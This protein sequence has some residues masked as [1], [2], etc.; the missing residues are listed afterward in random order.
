[1]RRMLIIVS[2][3]LCLGCLPAVVHAEWQAG[4]G[5]EKITP[6]QPM[7]L[8]GYGG[9]NQ[10]AEGTLHDLWAKAI[11]LQNSAGQRGVIISLDLVGISREMTAA[12]VKLLEQ[13][14]LFQRAEIAICTSHT[15]CGPVTAGTLT[16]MYFLDD[17]QQQLVDQYSA[18]LP[19][20]IVAAVEKALQHLE[21]VTLKFACGEATFAV[22]RRN[23]V[24]AEV[25]QLREAGLLEGPVD[26]QVPTLLVHDQQ[27]QV[28]G[29]V[30]GYACHATTLGFYQ[31][32][33]DWP[34]FAQLEI[35]KLYPQATAMFVA[36]CGA[37]QNP[38]PRRQVELAE[39]YGQQIA[40][41]IAQIPQPEWTSLP[42]DFR[43]QYQEL[44]LPLA[45]LPTREQ[46]ADEAASADR[47]VANRARLLLE[48]WEQT[49]QLASSYSYPVQVW[50]LGRV[51]IVFLGGEVVVDY[52]LRLK[53]DLQ[54]P[55]A[56]I[57][58]Y[59]N[60]VMAYIP[61]RR[62][63]LEGGYEGARSM[64]YYGLP[65]VWAPEIELLIVNQVLELA[66]QAN[67]SEAVI[68]AETP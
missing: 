56:W 66:K 1:M 20:K 52:S 13:K 17:E 54:T 46:L 28:K 23:N 14:F 12:V 10:P 29:V 31:W 36:G 8:S 57:A 43:V 6:E 45:Q 4:L 15:H 38:L 59:C 68:P 18:A 39:L 47:F 51:P 63:L 44:D 65:T 42:E 3:W 61:S 41:A 2:C 40:T 34:G 26:H 25:P 35:E 33:G 7:W 21:P 5:R 27:E 37:D 58:G 22:N 9:R 55:T 16:T 24:E 48:Q 60:D 67:L 49:G 64:I 30:F 32:C 11:V 62:V 19:D 53:D 50:N